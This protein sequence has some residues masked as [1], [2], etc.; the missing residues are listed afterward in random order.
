MCA[1]I[2]LNVHIAITC[3]VFQVASYYFPPELKFMYCTYLS[4]EYLDY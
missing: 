3:L 4:D 2:E 1:N